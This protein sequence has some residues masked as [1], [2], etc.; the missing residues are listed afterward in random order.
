MGIPDILVVH[1]LIP[2]TGSYFYTD[3]RIH[4]CTRVRPK[5][6]RRQAVAPISAAMRRPGWA[7]QAA[8][9]QMTLSQG[10]CIGE[11]IDNITIY[12]RLRVPAHL[13]AGE[14]VLGFR[15]DCKST[16]QVWQACVD[17]TIVE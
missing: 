8:A 10:L 3:K 15:Y 16:A 12:D 1:N 11:W 9:G 6:R 14:Y 4:S 2:C 7:T 5:L 17:V 13:A